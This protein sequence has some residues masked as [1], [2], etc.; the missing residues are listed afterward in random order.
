MTYVADC[1]TCGAPLTQAEFDDLDDPE[2]VERIE[3]RAKREVGKEL[4]RI[5][6]A[7][8]RTM[9]DLAR[10]LKISVVELSALEVYGRPRPA[11]TEFPRCPECGPCHRVD[12]DGCCLSCGR[13][14][15]SGEVDDAQ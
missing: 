5:R 8:G 9:G 14:V 7:S 3:K 4:R 15:M 2:H 10:Y 12:E 11:R 1:P 6:R 13:D